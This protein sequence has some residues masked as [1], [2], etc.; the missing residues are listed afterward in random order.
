MPAGSTP[1]GLPY[2][3]DTDAV[4]QGAQA[5]KALAQAIEAQPW[6][7]FARW[8]QGTVAGAADAIV[9]AW[10]LTE[11]NFAANDA[12]GGFTCPKAGLYLVTVDLEFSCAWPAGGPLVSVGAK[13]SSAPPREIYLQRAEAS[14]AGATRRSYSVSGLLRMAVGETCRAFM[15]NGTGISIQHSSGITANDRHSTRFSA[16]WVAP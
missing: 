14:S 3:E 2:P 11:G 1:G 9:S 8:T 12:G 15:N 6:I 4:K 10:D 13:T 5:I 16:R 7:S